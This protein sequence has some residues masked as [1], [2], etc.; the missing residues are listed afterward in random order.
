M[1]KAFIFG[2]FMPFHKGHE[3]MINFALGKC[4][5]LSILICCSDKEKI[6]PKIR[7]SW[8]ETTFQ[9]SSKISITVFNYREDE[10]PNTSESSKETSNL[11]SKLFKELYPDYDLVITSEEYGNYVASYM[12]LEHIA[13]D[14]T[15][16]K[17]P[18]S[19]TSVRND[20]FNNWNFLPKSV[21][22]YFAIKIVIL[23]TESTGKT[24]LCN[25]LAIH[26]SCSRVKEAGRDLIA[27]SNSF[28]FKDLHRVS[29][30]H[31]KRIDQEICG[32]SPMLILDTDIHTTM[33]Y[34][35][36]IFNKELKV[37]AQIYK[38]NEAD[39]YL[40]LD[41]DVPYVQDGT[42]LSESDRNLLDLSH[43]KIL[44]EKHIKFI[45]I[46]GNWEQRLDKSVNEIDLMLR[47]KKEMSY[48]KI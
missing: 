35:K 42:R 47:K 46:K 41:K 32:E 8:I 18:I 25:K 7:K 12:G 43:R 38:S 20:L 28:K 45:E 40:Y 6:P 30:E 2:K 26:Y 44:K 39:L 17:F 22:S 19:A 31:A 23:G 34:A 4:D 37:A 14:P 9:L 16:Q 13:F 3:A 36:F 48:L 24:T 5:F 15:R 1:V 27:N 21:K 29:S 33:S 11:W 10:F